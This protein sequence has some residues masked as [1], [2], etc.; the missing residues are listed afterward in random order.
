MFVATLAVTSCGGSKCIKLSVQC[1]LGLHK[2][3][4]VIGHRL[5]TRIWILADEGQHREDQNE[6]EEY[7]SEDSVEDEEQDTENTVG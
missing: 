7:K 1:S 3:S 6:D 4:T 2:R 5:V